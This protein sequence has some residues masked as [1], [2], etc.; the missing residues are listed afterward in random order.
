MVE[1]KGRRIYILYPF[2][3]RSIVSLI[4]ISSLCSP[5][6]SLCRRVGQMT[7]FSMSGMCSGLL[8]SYRED[9]GTRLYAIKMKT[10]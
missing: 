9:A 8:I 10:T 6:S 2:M 3:S 1:G 5:L 7:I 4:S